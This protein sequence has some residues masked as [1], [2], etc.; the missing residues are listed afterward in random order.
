MSN[1]EYVQVLLG[2][3]EAQLGWGSSEKWLQRDFEN[4]IDRI[5]AATRVNLSLSTVKR[6]WKNAYK[7]LPNS[8]TLDALTRFAGYRDWQDFKVA[9]GIKK[10]LD[11]EAVDDAVPGHTAKGRLTLLRVLLALFLVAMVVFAGYWY[12]GRKSVVVYDPN[13]FELSLYAVSNE[14]PNTVFFRIKIPP[15]ITDTVWLQQDWDPRRREA[16]Q[17]TDTLIS[18]IYY[19]PGYYK[20]KLVVNHVVMQEVP[21][22]LFSNGWESAVFNDIFQREAPVYVPSDSALRAGE[23]HFA[24]EFLKHYRIDL[25]REYWVGYFLSRDFGSIQAADFSFEITVK[26]PAF[27][28]GLACRDVRIYFVFSNSYGLIPLCDS[29]CVSNIQAYFCGNYQNGKKADLSNFGADLEQWVQVRYEARAGH[30]K[31]FFN[32]T[33]RSEFD[34]EVPGA[35]L[36][37]I[38]I[39]TKG[40]GYWKEAK[41]FDADGNLLLLE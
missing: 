31:I 15:G 28:G 22:Q 1:K 5:Y 41:L 8:A 40:S 30:G 27:N 37:F 9:Q 10:V 4:L 34:Y 26:N 14:L 23:Y 11:D 6:I 17:P 29:G 32:N 12:F 20:A 21:L 33:L 24:P 18:S 7:E 36:R 25:S 19:A 35:E 16:L 39:Y 13:D 3:I 38:S 2:I